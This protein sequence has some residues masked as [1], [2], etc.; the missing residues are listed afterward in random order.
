MVQILVSYF[1]TIFMLPALDTH[2]SYARARLL[3]KGPRVV[4]AALRA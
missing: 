1:L 3:L 2:M 4:G